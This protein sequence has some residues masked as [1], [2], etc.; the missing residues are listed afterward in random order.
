MVL[1]APTDPDV[2]DIFQ[3]TYA[4]DPG[5]R[6]HNNFVLVDMHDGPM[7]VD[8]NLWILR[9]A[10]RTVLVDTG[11]GPRASRERGRPLDFDPVEGL[12]RIGVDPEAIEDIIVTHLHFDHAGNLDRFPHARLHIQDDEVRFAT[13]RCMCDR[14]LRRPFDV[15]DVVALIR[16]LYADRVEFHQGDGDVF[17][18]ISLVRC[19]GHSAAIQAVRVNTSRGLVVLGSDTS[20]YYANI[21]NGKP[22]NLTVDA[23]ATLQSYRRLMAIA[24]APDRFIPGHDPKVRRLFPTINVNGIDLV[25]LHMPPRPYD[26][27]DLLRTDDF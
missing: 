15:E 11:F 17:P 1:P 26:V 10:R 20:H 23:A 8:F 21:L 24:G 18:G 2:Y 14:F 19:A 7:P 9:N 6:V 13:G 3:M 25:A 16:S 22:F 4:N 27:A 5:R 12:T